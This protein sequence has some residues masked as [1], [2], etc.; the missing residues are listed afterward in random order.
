MNQ[1]LEFAGDGY[2]STRDQTRLT[3][4]HARVRDLMSDGAWRTLSLISKITQD[5]PA[6]VSA[7][8]RHMRKPRFGAWT[9]EKRYLGKGLYQYRAVLNS[10]VK[11]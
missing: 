10:G 3:H 11:N 1:Q 2:E 4:Q 8:L 6:S 5:P 9:V 7:Q